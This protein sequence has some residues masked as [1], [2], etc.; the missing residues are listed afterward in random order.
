MLTVFI[1]E[2]DGQA[3]IVEW[4]RDPK[5][6]IEYA[7]GPLIRLPCDQFRK[8]G[9][10]VVAEHFNK[11][12]SFRLDQKDAA[13]ILRASK[14]TRAFMKNQSAVIIASAQPDGIYLAPLRFRQFHLGGLESLGK[15]YH[16]TL[17]ANYTVNQFWEAFDKAVADAS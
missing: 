8:Q 10:K 2:R 7:T 15:E 11:Y 6:N 16:R 4:F 9:L 3:S 12:K 13:P 5:F 14:D 17:K 1:D